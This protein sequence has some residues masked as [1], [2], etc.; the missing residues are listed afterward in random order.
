MTACVA[1]TI[2]YANFEDVTKQ[3][4]IPYTSLDETLIG[5]AQELFRLVYKKRM[6]L[7]MVGVRFSNLVSGHEQIGLFTGSQERYSLYH[8]MDKIRLRFGEKAV[9]MASTM[10]LEL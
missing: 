2:R 5:K 4:T 3:A 7:R 9:T 10:N 8:A 6:L 1:I